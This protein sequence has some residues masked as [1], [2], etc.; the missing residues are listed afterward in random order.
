VLAGGRLVLVNSRG[1]I[2]FASPTDGALG[3]VVETKTPIS[4]PPVVANATLY[5]LD[6][7]GRL[8]AWR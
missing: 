8:A 7:K 5:T 1:Q 3:Q 2:A 6:D 4:L